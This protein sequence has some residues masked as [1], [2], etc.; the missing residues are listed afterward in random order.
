M[1]APAA[2]VR[3][4]PHRRSRIV[5]ALVAV[6]LAPA[7][8]A[9]G[10]EPWIITDTV[11]V[12]SPRELG[13]TIVFDGGVL[14]I[15]GVGE[16]GVS[17]AGNLMVL[18]TG[19]VEL[20][21]S[22][23][24]VLST[25]HGQYALAAL[26]HGSIAVTGCDYRV[27]AGVQHA[28]FSA[29]D[30]SVTVTDTTFGFAQLI[31]AGRSSFRATS[32]DGRFECIVQDD[33][34]MVLEG[35]PREVGRGE[36]WVW[37]E[38][39]SG[40]RARYSPPAPGY[41]QAWSF[42]PQ[43]AT[44][45]VQRCEVRRCQV[46]FWPMLVRAGSELVLHDIAAENWVIV[47][48]H[49]PNAATVA[50][51]VNG[52]RVEE[53]LLPLSDRTLRLE[54]ATV[55]TWNLYPEG[56]ARVEIERCLLGE[57]LT[58]DAA[59]AVLRDTIIDGTGGFFGA[60]GTSV[61]EAQGCTFTCDV[62][63]AREATMTLR[64]CSLRPYPQDPTG[65]WTRVGAYDSGRLLLDASEARTTPALGGQGL[66]AVTGIADPPPHPPGMGGRTTLHGWAA[67]FALDPAVALGQW[68]LEAVPA[69]GPVQLL[70]S[71]DGN[72]DGGVLGTWADAEPSRP[73]E[74]RTVL[75]DG[76]GRTLVGRHAVP[77]LPPRVRQGVVPRGP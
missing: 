54:R 46:A 21:D 20:A 39:P 74:L 73:W 13:D 72:V 55:D 33:A 49:M 71:G 29:E 24:R 40:S 30:A 18:G 11:V 1:R 68:R 37:P 25:Y 76:L 28:I 19:R 63:V 12:T 65:Q 22:V 53:G 35:I 4:I 9:S 66:I 41:I 8:G 77:A 17:L 2:R 60:N 42:P 57:V 15:V 70:G 47:G 67:L 10:A 62:Q 3:R 34:T 58:M 56:E 7:V 75:T 31:A 51:V 14:R 48:L 69:Q 43:G 36:L 27:P 64:R 38:F 23:V 6:C 5:V 45:I 26:G 50:D 44:G 32:L 16:P 61:I 52:R 59:T